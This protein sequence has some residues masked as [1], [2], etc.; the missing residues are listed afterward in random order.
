[1]QHFRGADSVQDFDPEVFGPALADVGR[2][3]L[4]GG[5]AHANRDFLL[6]GQ[7]GAGE[8]CR[9]QRRHAEKDRR[10][11]VLEMFEHRLRV[12]RSAISTE[13]APTERG[14]VSPL[15]KP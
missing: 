6:R 11:P 13:V 9:V 5:N 4:A 2:Q 10:P 15:P 3:R 12:S 7:I 8:Q 14:K 1:M